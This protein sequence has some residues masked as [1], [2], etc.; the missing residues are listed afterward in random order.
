[1]KFLASGVPFRT[2]VDTALAD[3]SARQLSNVFEAVG[4]S[5]TRKIVIEQQESKTTTAR[6]AMISE[7][8]VFF[9][10]LSLSLSL[11]LSV[12][13]SVSLSRERERESER[14]GIGVCPVPKP[15]SK[16]KREGENR[17]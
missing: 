14:A 15:Q 11:S 1:M 9:F 2:D 12:S 16:A 6:A 8:G 7:R 10:S 3:G 5:I 17:S 13:V 4:R